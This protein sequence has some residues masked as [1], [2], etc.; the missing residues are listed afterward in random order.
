MAFYNFVQ[1][2]ECAEFKSVFQPTDRSIA[3]V[4]ERDGK[5]RAYVYLREPADPA[6]LMLKK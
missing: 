2:T 6:A 1:A 4:Y 5:T 3:Y